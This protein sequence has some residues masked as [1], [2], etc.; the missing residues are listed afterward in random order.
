MLDPRQ[1][2]CLLVIDPRPC[3]PSDTHASGATSFT[4]HSCHV[5]TSS[6]PCFRRCQLPSS[7]FEAWLKYRPSVAK[8]AFSSVMTAVPA[9][10]ENPHMYSTAISFNVR[11]QKHAS[12]LGGHR[13]ELCTQNNDCP[14]MAR[15][16][17]NETIEIG[18]GISTK[19]TVHI[20]IVRSHE[21]SKLFQSLGGVNSFHLDGKGAIGSDCASSVRYERKASIYFIQR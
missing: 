15:L 16:K 18:I 7:C 10:P 1:R 14:P 19:P 8:A 5:G 13:K 3:L 6:K 4:D 11:L 9:E 12:N 20:Y 21:I 2:F 17:T